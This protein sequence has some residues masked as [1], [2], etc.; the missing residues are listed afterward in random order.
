MKLGHIV[1]ATTLCHFCCRVTRVV[2]GRLQCAVSA[3]LC[4]A[5]CIQRL[6]EMVPKWDGW[7]QPSVVDLLSSIMKSDD[8]CDGSSSGSSVVMLSVRRPT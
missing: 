7:I 6:M 4:L 2:L 3:A 8:V 5:T 1:F